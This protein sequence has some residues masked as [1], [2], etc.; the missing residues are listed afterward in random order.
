[1]NSSLVICHLD[2]GATLNM[3]LTAEAGQRLCARRRQPPIDAP[4]GSSRVDA[5]YSPVAR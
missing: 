3:E 4:I 5:L 2:E 1:M